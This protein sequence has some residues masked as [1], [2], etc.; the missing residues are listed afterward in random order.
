MCHSCS[1]TT[2]RDRYQ[3][4]EKGLSGK[5][6]E[7]KARK[8]PVSLEVTIAFIQP[9]IMALS[10]AAASLYSSATSAFTLYPTG[11]SGSNVNLTGTSNVTSASVG[12]VNG[13]RVAPKGADILSVLIGEPFPS[14]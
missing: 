13:S 14:S 8:R 3:T 11:G 6:R 12:I 7:I 4:I 1:F 9:H 10:M 2:L 5:R